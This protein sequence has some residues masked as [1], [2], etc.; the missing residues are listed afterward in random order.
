MRTIAFIF[1]GF[2]AVGLLTVTSRLEH[3]PKRINIREFTIHFKDVTF[4]LNAFGC[5]FFFWGT[6]IPLNFLVLSAESQGI[7]ANLAGYLTAVFNGVR[8]VEAFFGAS[9]TTE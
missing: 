1:L 9:Q 7:S 2:Q 3:T 5:F 8:Y 6:I 4:L